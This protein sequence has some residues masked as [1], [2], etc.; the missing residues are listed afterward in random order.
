MDQVL[1]GRLREHDELAQIASALA[2]GAIVVSASGEIVWIDENIRRRLNGGLEDLSLPVQRADGPAV[3]CFIATVEVMIE[4]EAARICVVQEI[5]ERKEPTRD[6][7]AAVEAVMSDTSRFTRTI[8]EKLKTLRQATPQPAVSSE[9]D[10]LT[11]REREVLGLICE[12]RS[13]A[14]MGKVLR[15]SQ[16]TVR[17]HIASLYRKIGVNRRGAAIIWARERGITGE[18]D[19]YPRGPRRGESLLR[20]Y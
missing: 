14:D 2:G 1:S 20:K 15:L 13:D 11:D 5:D 18:L 9:L 19:L 12:G 4:G 17:N 3:D 7:I 8:V 6:L 16:N 10:L